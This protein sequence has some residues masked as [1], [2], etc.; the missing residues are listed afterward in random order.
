MMVMMMVVLV[1]IHFGLIWRIFLSPDRFVS[2]TFCMP[3][4]LVDV[5][6]VVISTVRSI[7][8]R[9]LSSK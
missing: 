8:C 9:D 5:R 2:R 4:F 3:L 6:L 1:F 7:V